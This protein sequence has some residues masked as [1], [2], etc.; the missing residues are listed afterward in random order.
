MWASSRHIPH[1]PT[2]NMPSFRSY[3]FTTLTCSQHAKCMATTLCRSVLYLLFDFARKRLSRSK[4]NWFLISKI[5]IKDA[6]SGITQCGRT[7]CGVRSV[8]M[9]LDFGNICNIVWWESLASLA[10]ATDNVL[11]HTRTHRT[12]LIQTMCI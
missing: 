7:R 10:S 4:R 1:P 12:R 6:Q 11:L 9:A 5:R 8:Y 3:F 2:I